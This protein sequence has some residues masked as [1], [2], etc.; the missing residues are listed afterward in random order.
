M[1]EVT[2]MHDLCQE[3]LTEFRA[4][5]CSA[6]A[7]TGQCEWCKEQA[8][9]LRDARDYDEGLTGR[10]YRVCS[11][12]KKRRDDRIKEELEEYDNWADHGFPEDDE[13]W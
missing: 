1:A 7:R 3:C 4:D 9:D 5:E 10:V 8:T 11:A 13:D 2:E 12:C 6:E